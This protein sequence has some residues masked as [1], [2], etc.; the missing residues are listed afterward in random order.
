MIIDREQYPAPED[1]QPPFLGPDKLSRFRDQ[2]TYA[3]NFQI[4]TP[5]SGKAYLSILLPDEIAVVVRGALVKA[6]DYAFEQMRKAGKTL[7]EADLSPKDHKDQTQ[8]WSELYLP[9]LHSSERVYVE[10]EVGILVLTAQLNAQLNALKI[11]SEIGNPDQL[12]KAV[13]DLY[14]QEDEID[15]FLGHRIK[16]G[17]EEYKNPRRFVIQSDS[18]ILYRTNVNMEDLD[19]DPSTR[20]N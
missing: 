8:K 4:K 3:D 5:P 6:Q 2:F 17:N 19:T 7:A 15:S 14:K 10:A 1:D 9:V 18:E 11:I 13:G 16:I 20:I 12:L